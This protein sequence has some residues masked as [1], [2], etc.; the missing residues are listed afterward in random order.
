MF[1]IQQKPAFAAETTPGRP[2]VDVVLTTVLSLTGL[3]V[4]ALPVH[5]DAA[6]ACPIV[7]FGVSATRSP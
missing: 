1:V 3:R 2:I 7:S 6:L 4:E 5:V